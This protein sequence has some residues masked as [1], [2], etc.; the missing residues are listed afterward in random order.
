[1]V[2]SS[3]SENL[4]NSV[5]MCDLSRVVCQPVLFVCLFLGRG[6][7]GRLSISRICLELNR[8]Y[9]LL[10]IKCSHHTNKHISVWL[11]LAPFKHQQKLKRLICFPHSLPPMPKVFCFSFGVNYIL[12]PRKIKSHYISNSKGCLKTGYYNYI[13]SECYNNLTFWALASCKTQCCQVLYKY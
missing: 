7:R 9:F 4:E 1:M 6:G 11:C 8:A 5:E 12:I 10:H 13:H 3:S 2:L